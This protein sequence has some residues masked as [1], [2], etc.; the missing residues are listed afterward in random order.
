M[1]SKQSITLSAASI[2]VTFAK[3]GARHLIPSADGTFLRLDATNKAIKPSNPR[4]VNDDLAS[5]VKSGFLTVEVFGK[6]RFF[7]LTQH[8]A[9]FAEQFEESSNA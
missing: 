7:E 6:W 1:T 5:L 3:S 8:G 9:T 4:F 2:L